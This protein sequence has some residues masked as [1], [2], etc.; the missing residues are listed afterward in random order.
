ML[1]LEDQ[2]PYNQIQEIVISK[3]PYE[4]LWKSAVKFHAYHDKWMNGPVLEV[5]AEEVDQ[6][7]R[8]CIHVLFN[9]H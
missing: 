3:E 8:L 9:E 4:R 1:Q 7:V 6:E 2:T 5:I